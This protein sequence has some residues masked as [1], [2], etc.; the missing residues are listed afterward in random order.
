VTYTSPRRM[1]ALA[2]GIGKGLATQ[3]HEKILINQPVC[4]HK[5]ADRC[6]ILFQLG[7]A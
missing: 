2:V 6:E 1:C 7:H 4:M 3:F 5:G